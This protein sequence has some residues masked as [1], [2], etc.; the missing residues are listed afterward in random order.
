MPTWAMRCIARYGVGPALAK[1]CKA[2]CGLICCQQSRAVCPTLPLY[3]V[4]TLQLNEQHGF[5]ML[6]WHDPARCAG[7]LAPRQAV[8][9]SVS[10]GNL[11]S[12]ADRQLFGKQQS[13]HHL[14]SSL[15]HSCKLKTGM[16]NHTRL[17]SC[18]S[19]WSMIPL[20]KA[21]CTLSYRPGEML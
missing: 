10:T 11:M 17:L 6:S 20:V 3:T 5:C 15:N 21:V 1:P 12:L 16:G 14:A 7:H 2:C 4:A 13:S 18:F 9:A 19:K 8:Y